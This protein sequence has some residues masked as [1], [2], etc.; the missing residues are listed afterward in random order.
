[1]KNRLRTLINIHRVDHILDQHGLI[2]LVLYWVTGLLSIPSVSRWARHAP[3]K[4]PRLRFAYNEE[5]RKPSA[6]WQDAVALGLFALTPVAIRLTWA[7]RKWEMG[8]GVVLSGYLIYDALTR[9]LRILWFDDLEPDAKGERRNVWSHRRI[10]FLAIFSY[11]QAILLFPSIF[12][13]VHL[14][15]DITYASLLERS[16]ANATLI[17]LPAPTSAMDVIQISVSLIYLTVVIATAASI[18]YQRKELAS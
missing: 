4:Y 2:V 14:A 3:R 15:R 17:W 9:H 13:T 8:I 1:M 16:F 7:D 5:K 12:H 11:A 10:L 18:S 6:A